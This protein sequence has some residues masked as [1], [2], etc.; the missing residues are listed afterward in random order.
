MKGKNMMIES[1]ISYFEKKGNINF[2]EVIKISVEAAIEKSIN[3]IVVFAAR[4]GSV[5]DLIGMVEGK[6]IEIIVASYANGRVFY[7]GSSNE[8]ERHEVVPEVAT[9]AVRKEFFERGIKYVQ[10]GM[11]LEPI[12]SCTGDNST[13]MIISTLN[14]ISEGLVHCINGAVMAC[15][16]GFINDNEKIISI[17]GDTAVVV[18]PT[19]KRDMFSKNFRIHN[20]LCKPE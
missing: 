8:E 10:G 12:V 1:K 6:K 3:K 18:T 16:N 20:I 5:N 15:E 2:N 14:I 9:E 7:S 13:E 17:S 4:V 19:I 11:P